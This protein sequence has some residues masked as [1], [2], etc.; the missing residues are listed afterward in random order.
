MNKL[1]K[2]L[3]DLKQTSDIIGLKA[4]FETEGASYK[5]ICRLKELALKTGLLTEIKIGGCGAVRDLFECKELNADIITSPMIESA[6]ALKKFTESADSV[7]GSKNLP[8]LYINIETKTAVNNADE[9]IKSEAFRRIDGIILGRSD[10]AS[11]MNIANASDEKINKIIKSLYKKAGLY[12]KK[13]ITGGK[14]KPEEARLLAEYAD[15]IET[16]KIMFGRNVTKYNIIKA[17]EFEILWMQ[18]KHNKTDMDIRRIDELTKRLD[19]RE[20][21]RDAV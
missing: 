19:N 20:Y 1:I 4:E 8:L 5:D 13:F 10:L 7:Y 2:I 21:L 9:I 6:Y 12:N 17:I 14:I 15:Y 16:R 3:K 11:S 18:N